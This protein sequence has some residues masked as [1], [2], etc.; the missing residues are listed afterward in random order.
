MKT[1]FSIDIN[2]KVELQSEII[3]NFEEEKIKLLNTI[4]TLEF[5][6]GF[7]KEMNHNAFD[8]AKALIQTME[9]Q[10][11]ELSTATND[12]N[13]LKEQYKK[14]LEQ[15]EKLKNNYQ[16]AIDA[17]VSE[18]RT[19]PSMDNKQDKKRKIALLNRLKGRK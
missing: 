9:K 4:E 5:E 19:D 10:I 17:I 1:D 18:I 14:C 12:I 11:H 13:R 3:K 16:I 15:A 6:K 2:R 7:D 8:T